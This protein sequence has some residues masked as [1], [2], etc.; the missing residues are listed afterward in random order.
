MDWLGAVLWVK[1]VSFIQI[2]MLLARTEW[3]LLK[4]E[5]PNDTR[6]WKLALCNKP[7]Y[8]EAALL[9]YNKKTMFLVQKKTRQIW[10]FYIGDSEAQ[11]SFFTKSY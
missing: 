11:A 8:N 5:F 10:L 9:E 2:L 6:G 4:W 1:H 7:S 3:K